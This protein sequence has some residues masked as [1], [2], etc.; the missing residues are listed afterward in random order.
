MQ[1]EKKTI[2]PTKPDTWPGWTLQ[3]GY[4]DTIA[5]TY[6]EIYIHKTK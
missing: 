5:N 3:Q 1:F 6:I 2:N 4:N